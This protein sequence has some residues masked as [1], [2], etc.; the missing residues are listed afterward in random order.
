[1]IVLMTDCNNKHSTAL[2]S[3]KLIFPERE[4][5]GGRDKEREGERER[6]EK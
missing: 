6:K 4:A 1:M 2:N 5:T 3:S